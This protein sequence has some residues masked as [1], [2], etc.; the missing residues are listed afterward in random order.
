MLTLLIYL[1]S[2][3]DKIKGLILGVSIVAF[4]II[5]IAWI[6]YLCMALD[7]DQEPVVKWM[8]KYHKKILLIGLISVMLNIAIPSTKVIGAMYLLPKMVNGVSEISKN[9]KVKQLPDK[10]LTIFNKKL[11][12]YIEDFTPTKKES[13]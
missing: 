5:G 3:V 4:S 8:A 13:K 2:I 1:L 12:E 6:V 11:D 9:Q 10:V 7:G